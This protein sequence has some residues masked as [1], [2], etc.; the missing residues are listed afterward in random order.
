[1]A[2][3]GIREYFFPKKKVPAESSARIMCG[4]SKGEF[5]SLI[6]NANVACD[7]C[8]RLSAVSRCNSFINVR[9]VIANSGLN[10]EKNV[11]QLANETQNE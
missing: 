3:Q 9:Q 4:I 2:L 5:L 1:M 7:M 6:S 10:W 11:R 8:K